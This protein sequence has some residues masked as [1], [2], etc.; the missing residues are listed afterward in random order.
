MER[1]YFICFDYWIDNGPN[2]YWTG[3]ISK[4]LSKISIP[5]ITEDII[6]SM[7]NSLD[8]DK[9]QV[10]VLTFNNIEI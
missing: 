6:G 4:D 1:T 10:K 9:W 7:G 2:K 8:K 3:I 5:Q